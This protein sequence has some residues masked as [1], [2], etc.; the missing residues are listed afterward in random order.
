MGDITL[1][2]VIIVVLLLMICIPLFDQ[3][4]YLDQANSFDYAL[5]SLKTML[6]KS[7]S[8][9]NVADISTLMNTILTDHMDEQYNLIY[10]STPFN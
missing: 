10:F 3:D 1:K 9:L 7:P 6:Y 5:S 2:K 8:E 4:I